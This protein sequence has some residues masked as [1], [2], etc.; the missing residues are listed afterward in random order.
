MMHAVRELRGRRYEKIGIVINLLGH[1]EYEASTWTI[2]EIENVT[3]RREWY[4]VSDC[5][6]PGQTNSFHIQFQEAKK[7]TFRRIR[8]S[9]YCSNIA[10]ICIEKKQGT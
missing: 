7:I 8:C 4:N 10:N 2:R 9:N 5:K 3:V 1:F 6:Y